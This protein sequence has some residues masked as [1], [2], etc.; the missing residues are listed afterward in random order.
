MPGRLEPFLDRS[1]MARC[2]IC[3]GVDLLS[4]G[5]IAHEPDCPRSPC[6]FCSKTVMPGEAREVFHGRTAHLDCRIDYEH[7]EDRAEERRRG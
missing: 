7:E 6:Q 4:L 5:F 3:H 2:P 1:R